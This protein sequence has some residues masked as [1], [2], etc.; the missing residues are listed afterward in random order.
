[1]ALSFKLGFALCALHFDFVPELPLD[2]HLNNS[3][4][5]FYLVNL[6]SCP[7]GQTF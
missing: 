4:N 6:V 3:L 2:N 7:D 5:C 1:M